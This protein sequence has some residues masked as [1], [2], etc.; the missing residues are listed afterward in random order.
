LLLPI[1]KATDRIAHHGLLQ[2]AEL[3]QLGRV[4]SRCLS[5]LE[6]TDKIMLAGTVDALEV[7][8]KCFSAGSLNAEGI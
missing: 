4:K 1:Y 7:L 2:K 8:C 6:Q 5:Y 3:R